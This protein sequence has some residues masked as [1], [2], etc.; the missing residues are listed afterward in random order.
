MKSLQLSDFNY[1]L[2]QE[3]IASL[4]LAERSSSRLLVVP[5]SGSTEHKQF[6]DLIDYLN[7]KDCLVF[8]NTKVMPARIYGNK[9]T[10]GK[11]E[12]LIERIFDR[13]QIVAHIK[14]NKAPKIE[15]V[16]EINGSPVF[17]IL[18]KT[19]SLYRLQNISELTIQDIMANHGE[20]PLPPYMKR[21]AT[22]SDNTRYQ[23]VYADIPG[24]VAAPTAGLHF[25][26][27]LI[28]AIKA[29]GVQTAEITLHVG[30]GTFLPVKV[31]NID[32]HVMHSE[33]I[34]ISPA[35]VDLI[36]KTKKQGGRVFAVGTTT[37]RCLETASL[38]GEL[39]AYQG[40]TDIFI[41]PGFQFKT[42]DN[43]ITNF[44]LP[45]STL[46]MLVSAFSGY[47]R[48]LDVYNEAIEKQYRFFSY[49][50]AMLL[51]RS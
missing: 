17:K 51:T 40:E 31:D 43:L 5:K 50:D 1:Q 13:N 21:S 45:E 7:S 47:Q 2:P 12:I 30:S 42:V 36:K 10:G 29:K 39:I 38:S 49:G 44:H 11:I 28:K 41:K 9:V 4:P 3:L 33:W 15:S 24:A 48:I 6:F 35:V 27:K 34:Q 23:T 20:M 18:S 19:D 26:E 46:L 8:N 14:A 25:D 16:I 22:D 37:L 32:N